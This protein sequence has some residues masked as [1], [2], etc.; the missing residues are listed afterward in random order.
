[1]SC[2]IGNSLYMQ[3][4]IY[5]TPQLETTPQHTART[6]PSGH[7]R[8]RKSNIRTV[9]G[10]TGRL[11]TM[12]HLWVFRRPYGNDKYNTIWLASTS[13]MYYEEATL[14]PLIMDSPNSGHL[15]L[16]DIWPLCYCVMLREWI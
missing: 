12:L 7:G 16:T 4:Y 3:T 13:Y 10:K 9:L 15:H 1:M 14:E 8:D 11:A 6:A 5:I 2:T